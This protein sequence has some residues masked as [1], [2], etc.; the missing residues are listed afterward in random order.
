VDLEPHSHPKGLD[1]IVVVH[2]DVNKG[3]G[4]HSKTERGGRV[5]EAR[6]EES[7]CDA[8]DCQ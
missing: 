8:T 1:A 3:V 5:E 6:K 7:S 2:K 4:E